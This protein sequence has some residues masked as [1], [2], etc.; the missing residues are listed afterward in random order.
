LG[1]LVGIDQGTSGT[2]VLVLDADLEVQAQATRRVSSRHLGDG[3]VEQDPLVI[4]ASL[5][6]AC[7]EVLDGFASD[8]EAVGLAHQGETVVAW[9]PTTLEPLTPAVVWSDRRSQSVIDRLEEDD[10]RNRVEELSGMRLDS[11]FCAAKYRWMLEE[12][13][14]LV[15]R[16]RAGR[17]RFG[18]L[19]S[20]IGLQLGAPFTTD[21]GTASRTQLTRPG[22]YV[23]DPDLIG[24]FGLSIDWLA[25][26]KPTVHDRGILSHLDWGFELPLRAVLVDQP[27]ALVGNGGLD[28]GMVKV[29]YGTG[30]FVVANAG[31]VPPSRD[32]SVIA[33][34]GWDD[35]QGPIYVLDGGVLSVGSALDWLSSLGVEIDDGTHRRL[36]GRGPS[37]LVVLPS[38][39]GTGAPRWQRTETASISGITSATTGDDLVHGFLDSFAFRIAEILEA[40][41]SNGIPRPTELTADGG[42]SQSPYLMQRQADVLGI[43]VHVA[44]NAEAT[45]L[46][47]AL[48]AGKREKAFGGFTRVFHPRDVEVSRQA[49]DRWSETIDRHR[50]K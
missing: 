44:D 12:T 47:A 7:G 4:L 50:P 10:L 45:A 39:V 14:D 34:V 31:R 3:G 49:F 26:I 36:D 24:L 5:V 33:S 11:Y 20:W 22:S 17:A 25:P 23:W 6:E 15:A 41:I 27:A 1:V 46:G 21:I 28:P 2:T 18:T 29:T 8:V 37:S 43:P 32:L 30:A 16:A 35:D 19:D 42:L 48:I 38:L 13:P 9:D 40:M